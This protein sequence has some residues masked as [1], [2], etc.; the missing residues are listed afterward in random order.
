MTDYNK[1]FYLWTQKQAALIR[2]LEIPGL[3]REN[4]AEEI[5]SIGRDFKRQCLGRFCYLIMELLLFKYSLPDDNGKR[6]SNINIQLGRCELLT[7]VEESPNFVKVLEEN[8]EKCYKEATI[9]AALLNHS[10]IIEDFFRQ[11]P[12]S[13]ER[14]LD[15]NFFPE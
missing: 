1:D 7:F 8:K 6:R 4:V 15:E 12:F 2:S 11:C 9:M 10:L 14:I 5:E 3:D 13:L